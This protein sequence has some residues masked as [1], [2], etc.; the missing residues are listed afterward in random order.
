MKWWPITGITNYFTEKKDYTTD[1][2]IKNFLK[3]KVF[4]KSLHIFVIDA[5][6]SNLLNFTIK[7]FKAPQYNMHRFGLFFTET[8]RH[9]DLLIVL[10]PVNKKMKEPLLETINQIPSQCGVLVINEE[11]QIDNELENLNIPNLIATVNK[12]I[13]PE[14]LLSILLKIAQGE[15][16]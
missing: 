3:S 1:L 14:E 9:A 16:K 13:S 7:A 8:P 2:K 10:G 12:N 5:G 11:F 4:K 6:C 15:S